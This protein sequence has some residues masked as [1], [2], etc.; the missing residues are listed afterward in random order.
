[1]EYE[2]N[3]AAGPGTAAAASEE[4]PDYSVGPAG[5]HDARAE[6]VT[7]RVHVPKWVEVEH[8]LFYQFT[9]AAADPKLRTD[10]LAL[11]RRRRAHRRYRMLVLAFA[12][13]DQQ[14]GLEVDPRIIERTLANGP[15]PRRLSTR[16]WM[17]PKHRGHP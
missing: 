1:M 11:C 10:A 12:W 6:V 16:E 3:D 15:V 8:D 5:C 14:H 9:A 4:W 2:E 7:M 17:S 13:H